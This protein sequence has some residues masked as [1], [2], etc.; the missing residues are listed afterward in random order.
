MNISFS[1]PDYLFLFIPVILLLVFFYVSGFKNLDFSGLE[2]LKKVYKWNSFIY[3]LKYIIL[4]LTVYFLI[5]A[6]ANPL[7]TYEKK[8]YGKLKLHFIMDL[9]YS[10][11]VNDL[12]WVSRYNVML[13]WIKS[14]DNWN[15]TIFAGWVKKIDFINLDEINDDYIEKL[16]LSNDWSS[17]WDAILFSSKF[18]DSKS[19]NLFFVLSDWVVNEGKDIIDS[20]I[21]LKNIDVKISTFAIW[22]DEATE[23]FVDNWLWDMIS[24]KVDIVDEITLKKIAI[25]TSWKFFRIYNSETL[26]NSINSI[27]KENN[28]KVIYIDILIAK[29]LYIISFITFIFYI[30]IG[31]KNK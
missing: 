19:K 22:W 17:L 8:D 18:L 14:F 12:G 10:M 25:E 30:I 13:N 29:L 27:I 21:Y 28:F 4:F 6:L 26:N 2:D 24:K 15:Y 9:S 11:V 7:I 5:L 31:F 16:N 23:V 3:K 1:Y 20:L